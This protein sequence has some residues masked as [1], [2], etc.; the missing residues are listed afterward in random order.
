MTWSKQTLIQLAPMLAGGR[1]QRHSLS[2]SELPKT[3]HLAVRSAQGNFGVRFRAGGAG[4][5]NPDA[6]GTLPICGK[7]TGTQTLLKL[8]A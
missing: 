4:L 1:I 3:L 5:P 7:V 6:I 2:V 8:F